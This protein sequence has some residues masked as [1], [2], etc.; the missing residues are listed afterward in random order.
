MSALP[1]K[2]FNSIFNS[3]Q[4][5]FISICTNDKKHTNI[6]N[7]QNGGIVERPMRP[8]VTTPLQRKI[9]IIDTQKQKTT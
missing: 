4:F 9:I 8:E 3:I 1:S 7:K 5:K 2:N 6:F